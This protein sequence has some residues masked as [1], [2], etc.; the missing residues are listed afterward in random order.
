M[1]FSILQMV[2]SKFLNDEGEDDE[3]FNTE[4]AQSADLTIL[5]INRLEKDFLKAI[6]SKLILIYIILYI[7]F[8]NFMINYNF[9]IYDLFIN[10][11]II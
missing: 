9:K 10:F 2:A 3:V 4:W 11:I 6:V 7:Y 1:I 5:Q 8:I